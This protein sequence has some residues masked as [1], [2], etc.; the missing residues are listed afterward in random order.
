MDLALRKRLADLEM[1]RNTL[2]KAM[3]KYQDAKKSALFQY[4]NDNTEEETTSLLR[5]GDRIDDFPTEYMAA[6]RTVESCIGEDRD[7]S[8]SDS[9]RDIS[10]AANRDDSATLE[11][12]N[13]REQIEETIKAPTSTSINNSARSI[14]SINSLRKEQRSKVLTEKRQKYRRRQFDTCTTQSIQ[15][16][17]LCSNSKYSIRNA[18]FLGDSDAPSDEL[19]TQND[20]GDDTEAS[21]ISDENRYTTTARGV[22]KSN[23]QYETS[24]EMKF[25]RADHTPRTGSETDN[26]AQL[27]NNIV[28]RKSMNQIGKHSI[29]TRLKEPKES[30]IIRSKTLM[31]ADKIQNRGKLLSRLDEIKKD[32]E[33]RLTENKICEDRNKITNERTGKNEVEEKFLRLFADKEDATRNTNADEREI[34]KAERIA[35][36][37]QILRGETSEG[38]RKHTQN[39]VGLGCK[40]ETSKGNSH[41]NATANDDVDNNDNDNRMTLLEKKLNMMISKKPLWQ[42]ALQDL[43]DEPFDAKL[44]GATSS[45]S[46][47]TKP[48]SEAE[49]ICSSSAQIKKGE[50]KCSTDSSLET[51]LQSQG[52][53]TRNDTN[54]LDSGAETDTLESWRNQSTS[55]IDSPDIAAPS[56][57]TSRHK[58]VKMNGIVSGTNLKVEKGS[59]G[60]ETGTIDSS[61]HIQDAKTYLDTLPEC[62]PGLYESSTIG[63]KRKEGTETEKCSFRSTQI[64]TKVLSP[65]TD[66]RENIVEQEEGQ[67]NSTQADR[68]PTPTTRSNW[69]QNI[70]IE[71]ENQIE[72]ET[73]NYYDENVQREY[74]N[75]FLPT[76]FSSDSIA[77]LDDEWMVSLRAGFL[78][79][80]H[81][82]SSEQTEIEFEHLREVKSKDIAPLNEDEVF[83]GRH[84]QQQQILTIHSQLN[85]H[86]EVE[87]EPPQQVQS[88]CTQPIHEE[89]TGSKCSVLQ[90]VQSLE[91]L[92]LNGVGEVVVFP[93]EEQMVSN[94]IEH[95]QNEHMV[96]ESSEQIKEADTYSQSLHTALED[97]IVS[98]CTESY[99]QIDIVYETHAMTQIDDVD[100]PLQ[101]DQ[102]M[103]QHVE[104]QHIETMCLQSNQRE[105]HN[106]CND[107]KTP[108]ASNTAKE[109]FSEMDQ[110]REV[111]TSNLLNCGTVSD[112]SEEESTMSLEVSSSSDNSRR[113]DDFEYSDHES[114]ESSTKPL[115]PNEVTMQT[116][117]TV[118]S[119]TYRA[120]NTSNIESLGEESIIRE[121]Q[122]NRK[123]T[124]FVV[125]S[126]NSESTLIA[127]Q[128]QTEQIET[129]FQ[130][131][132]P[133]ILCK[134][135]LMNLL[136]NPTL[137]CQCTGP[138]ALKDIVSSHQKG[139]S[140]TRK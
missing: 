50:S 137:L 9:R 115:I 106:F 48:P 36:F 58:E 116:D 16:P 30:K 91:S 6:V 119:I 109:Y 3:S 100:A 125:M 72:R 124:N 49:T 79:S 84:E 132:K 11:I 32:A 25:S 97:Q 76:S 85:Q 10:S 87:I 92:K 134:E 78:H 1:R 33:T 112:L 2:I 66:D 18:H 24:K 12:P 55:S 99:E 138:I 96:G 127:E 17:P 107:L 122:T 65:R 94:H 108:P 82:Q 51:K 19:T 111:K 41:E 61:Q 139:A 28:Y 69:N 136:K 105:R 5:S 98:Q 39:Y 75:G 117:F 23:K 21:P 35:N 29:V 95:Q 45:L 102:S 80:L 89:H 104:Q 133:K 90:H 15:K 63:E 56:R 135:S 54:D 13:V 53:W 93:N 38:L 88:K 114:E 131:D 44:S 64:Y 46:G 26:I 129:A 101:E 140:S 8:P 22:M 4:L 113:R 52:S 31:V 110:N 42:Q 120:S 86:I 40:T 20:A 74:I 123:H 59:S 47:I 43:Y 70:E 14:V 130:V 81:L 68:Q 67:M 126:S 37:G 62:L 7:S 118:Q 71:E 60:T 83:L 34:V 128:R 57:I 103:L 77:P 73:E 121:F 27:K